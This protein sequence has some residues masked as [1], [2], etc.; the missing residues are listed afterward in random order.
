MSQ[1]VPS[2]APSSTSKQAD[3]NSKICL[4]P[5]ADLEKHLPVE[6]WRHLFNSLYLKTDADVVENDEN[7]QQEVRQVL[8]LTGVQPQD[9]I[10]DLCCGQ[11]RHS[12]ALALRGFPHVVGLDRSRYLIR[13]ARRRAA[14][15]GLKTLQFREGDARKTR[16]QQNSFDLVMIMG[17]SFGYFEREEEN[18]QVLKEVYRLLKPGGKLLLDITHGS[19]MKE[20]FSPK[21]WEWINEDQL[22]CRERNLTK[23]NQRLVTREVVIHAEKGVI[24]D[25]F[26]AERLYSEEELLAFIKKAGF[27]SV[28]SH[29]NIIA[30][31]TRE[32]G[33]LGM[34][35]NRLLVTAKVERKITEVHGAH[36][37]PKQVLECTVLMGDPR[38]PDKVKLNGQFNNEDLETINRL[39]TGLSKLEGYRFYYQD[40]HSK[41]VKNLSEHRPSLIFNLCD[42]GFHNDAFKE[43]HVPAFLEML[44]IPYTGAG[45]RCLG[46]CYN[47]ALTTAWAKEMGVGTPDEI[48]ID[49]DNYST[50]IPTVFPSLVKPAF[51]DSSIG[52]TQEAFVRTSTELVDYCDRI[53]SEIPGVPI[54]V[55]E[56][57]SGSEYSVA[58]IGNNDNLTLLPIL[59][60]DYS[61]LPKHLPPILGYESKWMPDSPY[62]TD[63]KYREA[64]LSEELAKDLYDSSVLL[65]NR[66][67]CRDYAR[68]DY[69][70]DQNGKIKLLEVNPNPGWCWDGKLML[71]AS[72][73]GWT[74][75]QL[76]ENILKA[77]RER[78]NI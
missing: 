35:A 74:Y 39:K 15:L 4:G 30:K 34:M 68:F 60:V 55:Q 24:A 57:L 32:N 2:F 5:V 45:P 1:K 44:G 10:L 46:I 53:K 62:W 13:L 22:V 50:A 72:F 38:R 21:S 75:P 77:A 47:K 3:P 18:I 43:L 29:G 66:T 48:W 54:L 37:L 52:I 42:E 28:V 56:F 36:L 12:L 9:R 33:D 40:D 20:H 49:P 78:L 67:N 23:D 16:I 8:E 61:H 31:S 19:W 11:G 58:V 17:N 14:H 63:I 25:Q 73:A 41:L 27:D 71:M 76:L 51:G 26:Y 7:T 59:E 69:R 64:R 70:A 65:F 6:W